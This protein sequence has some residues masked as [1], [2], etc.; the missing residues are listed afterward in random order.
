MGYLLLFGLWILG[1]FA[2]A[3][4]DNIALLPSIEIPNTIS[5]TNIFLNLAY[6]FVN[7]CS[8]KNTLLSC[9]FFDLCLGRSDEEWD[10]DGDLLIAEVFK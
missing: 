2:I 4:I 5:D 1:L 10:V 9:W 3:R 6:V 7:F 8:I